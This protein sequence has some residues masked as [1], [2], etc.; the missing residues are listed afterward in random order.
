LAPSGNGRPT[1]LQALHPQH[2]KHKALVGDNDDDFQFYRD[3]IYSVFN[4][5]LIQAGSGWKHVANNFTF[6]PGTD[7]REQESVTRAVDFS[8][9]PRV[10]GGDKVTIGKDGAEDET[11]SH[12]FGHP[13]VIDFVRELEVEGGGE[14]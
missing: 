12:G 14:T 10:L 13:S 1:R 6:A 5:K 4:R 7:L 8:M 9:L 2:H 11:C 3:P